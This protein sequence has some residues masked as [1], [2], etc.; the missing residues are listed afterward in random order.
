MS[1]L[2]ARWA[3]GAVAL[4]LLLLAYVP[5]L[6]A[7]PNGSD[8]YYM[9]DVGETQVVL[10]VWGT[11][12]MTGYPLYVMTAG[13]AVA[14]LRAVG[15]S[16]VE[17][18]AVV[19]LLTMLAALA[20]VYALA[21]RITG[22]PWLS[23]AAVVALG[24]TRTIWIHA[25][26]AE[27]Y[28]LMVLLL[29][30]MLWIALTPRR[31][32]TDERRLYLLALLGGLGVA[33]HRALAMAIPAL[34]YAL[35]PV[36]AS[37]PRA[38]PRRLILCVLLGLLGFLPYIWLPLRAQAGAAWVYG[39]P[40]TLAGFLNE[41]LGSEASRFIGPPS[42]L[43]GLWANLRLVV[44]VLVTDLTWPGLLAGIIGLVAA[45][46]QPGMRRA[47]ITLLLLT[48]SAFVFHA[49]AYTDVL[50]ALILMITLPLALGWALLGSVVL[51]RAER[52]AT[53]QPL[54]PS[55]TQATSLHIPLS[56]HAE[57]PGGRATVRLAASV[58]VAAAFLALSAAFFTQNAPFIQSLVT[59]PTGLGIIAM[60][61]TAP[62]NATLM[63]PWGP[64]YFAA[65]FAR[66][67]L[68]TLPPDL[69]LVDHRADFAALVNSDHP[70]VTPATTFYNQS[71]DW[72][73]AQTGSPVWLTAAAPE[74]V[75]IAA[76]PQLGEAAPNAPASALPTAQTA[77]LTC[78]DDALDLTIDWLASAAPTEDWSVFVHLLDADGTILAQG[79]Q[80]APVFGW[81]P[82]TSWA[83]SELVR[84][85]YT[86][87]RV[88]GMTE[89]TYGL[90][91]QRPDGSF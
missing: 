22:R 9:M 54:F 79:D 11:L 78:R 43:D 85:I 62:P 59:D 56:V 52:A 44:G 84:D 25:E 90:Y 20:L 32:E 17:A 66:D 74:L 61:Q 77:S 7:I 51:D 68:N 33:H 3:A 70:L 65:G 48:V 50:S 13:P 75:R 88:P 6:Q 82:L 15:V 12:H 37:K 86:V 80:S 27:V 29:A 53:T 49:L 39:Q 89:L 18:P 60:S 63:I 1:P 23:A 36:L 58:A 4:G 42:T 41:F 24:L 83:A 76:A 91:R 31:P 40:G 57:K 55:P 46:F 73:Q 81:R 47:A 8:H 45:L 14:G 87:P 69:T 67:V 26:I 71:L 16:A 21:L 2:T 19:S 34:L 10:N 64:R 38:L 5:L 72:W 30:A 28:A 35:W